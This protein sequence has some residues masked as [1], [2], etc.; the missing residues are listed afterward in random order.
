MSLQLLLLL[1]MRG[2]THSSVAI[3]RGCGRMVSLRGRAICAPVHQRHQ[4]TRAV[5]SWMPSP[6]A[7]VS[8][9]AAAASVGGG[10]Q[11]QTLPLQPHLTSSSSSSSPSPAPAQ[12]RD[13]IYALA[14]AP[15]RAGVAVV[16]LSGR[17]AGIAIERMTGSAQKSKTPRQAHLCRLVHPTTKEHID[18]AIVLWFPGPRSFTGED[19]A[20]FHIHGGRS[21]IEALFEALSELPDTRMADA[22]EF[23]K[24]AFFNGKI[25]LTEV[26]GLADL[27]NAETRAQRQQALRQ[28]NGAMSR[29]FE[30]WRRTILKSMAHVEGNI[31][32]AETEDIEEN[33]MQSAISAVQTLRHEIAASL[34]DS[35]RGER[36]R[37][38]VSVAIVGAPNV[39]KSSLLNIMSQRPTAIVS[40]TAGTTRDILEV[41]LD[42]GGY[43]LLLCDTAGMRDS[44]EEIEQ[45][46]IKRAR[47][48][49]HACDLRLCVFDAS[50]L[51]SVD[52]SI[53][54]LVQPGM[55]LPI[56]NKID[57]VEASQLVIPPEILAA[58]PVF[59]SCKSGEGVSVLLERLTLELKQRCES[60]TGETALITQWRHRTQLQT[61]VAHL[62]HFLGK[63]LSRS[64]GPSS[65]VRLSL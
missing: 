17:A 59:L 21:I 7:P 57:T 62:D 44:D 16:R 25:D 6:L 1:L 36:L 49:A 53:L 33:V 50:K 19:V 14:T 5:C 11:S 46:G 23:T 39:G 9:T 35:R 34:N 10:A 56:I 20:E 47:A 54:Q 30:E 58:K 28:L 4:Q 40:A 61:C 31:D 42:I 48:R 3:S 29:T 18:D 41:P 12:Q 51:D 60:E 13:S 65:C 8:T 45:E 27:I 38:G 22:G 26:E 32:F 52:P 37:S 64:F 55:S 15:G 43:P 63:C 24:R 2:A